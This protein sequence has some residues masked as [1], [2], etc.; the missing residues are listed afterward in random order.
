MGGRR[1]LLFLL[2]VLFLLSSCGFQ[3]L[4]AKRLSK[5]PNA[6][7]TVHQLAGVEISPISSQP[8]SG[9]VGQSSPGLLAQQLKNALQD[10]LN[11]G[12]IVPPE[13]LYKLDITLGLRET[14]VAV[15]RD[16][17]ISRYNVFLDTTY[18]LSRKVDGKPVYQGRFTRSSSYNILAN[19]YFSTYVARDDSIKRGVNELAEEYR[20]RL[21]AFLVQQGGK[22]AP[23]IQLKQQTPQTNVPLYIPN[24][25]DN[26][27]LGT[28]SVLFPSGQPQQ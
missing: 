9:P 21:A 15:S 18:V 14:G 6:V 5:D 11:P 23:P 25:A 26:N 28:P 16:G 8:S 13:T 17:T 2:P 24:P 10:K 19:A 20:Q 12:N 22:L 7:T 3:P 1:L 4:Y 27:A